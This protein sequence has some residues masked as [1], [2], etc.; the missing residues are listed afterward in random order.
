MMKE[1]GVFEK[2]DKGSA[3]PESMAEMLVTTREAVLALAKN[4]I[5]DKWSEKFV[6][7]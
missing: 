5:E 3:T 6:A 2:H 7:K 4:Y 1:C